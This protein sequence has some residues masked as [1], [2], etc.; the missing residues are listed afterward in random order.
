MDYSSSVAAGASRTPTG[1]QVSSAA[2]EP[3]LM[4]HSGCRTGPNLSLE[5]M[6][7]AIGCH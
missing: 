3:D 2:L 4:P 6:E 5:S 1:M 7:L